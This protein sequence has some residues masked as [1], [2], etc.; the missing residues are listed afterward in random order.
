L[1]YMFIAIALFSLSIG[2]YNKDL[3]EIQLHMNEQNK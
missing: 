2:Q 3:Y 1:I